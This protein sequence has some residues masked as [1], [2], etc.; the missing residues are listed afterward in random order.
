ME[1]ATLFAGISALAAIITAA[2]AIHALS[3]TRA[4]S[5]EQTRPVVIAE[6]VPA[7]L[8]TTAVDLRIANYG[9]TA[10]LELSVH[11]EPPLPTTDHLGQDGRILPF[12]S[13]RYESAIPILPPGGALTNVYLAVLGDEEAPPTRTT[14]TVTYLSAERVRYRNKFVLDIDLVARGTYSQLSSSTDATKRIATA[15]ESLARQAHWRP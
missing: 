7:P 2:V 14:V 9:K 8:G 3:G 11:F 10:A 15:V 5:R 13:A 4:D 1:A 12:I 6:L